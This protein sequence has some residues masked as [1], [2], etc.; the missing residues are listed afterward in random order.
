MTPHSPNTIPLECVEKLRLSPFYYS[1]Q[2]S[3][4]AAALSE[5]EEGEREEER[6]KGRG[7]KRWKGRGRVQGGRTNRR[8]GEERVEGEDTIVY[9]PKLL[10]PLSEMICMN[11]ILYLSDTHYKKCPA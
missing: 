10:L 6:K 1:C 11:E 9:L 3:L 4:V 2:L 5:G 7:R 8:R